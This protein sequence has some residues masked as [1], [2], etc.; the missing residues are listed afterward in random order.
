MATRGAYQT[1]QKE[2]IADYFR[3]HP[4]DCVTAEAVY[5]ALDARVGMTTVYRAVTRLCSEGVLRKY[6]GQSAG[7][8]AMY[9]YSPCRES[10]LHIRCLDCGAL[11]HLRCDVIGDFTQHLRGQH[12]FELD[13]GQTVLYGHCEQCAAKREPQAGK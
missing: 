5:A 13:E 8:A 6:A 11:A 12:G 2:V 7:E 10:H 4:E 3:A 1:K 9:Q